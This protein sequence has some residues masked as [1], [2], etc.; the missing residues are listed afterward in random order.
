MLYVAMCTTTAQHFLTVELN[1]Q[2]NASSC[3]AKLHDFH[4]LKNA[5]VLTSILSDGY[6]NVTAWFTK[7]ISFQQK[8]IK[9]LNK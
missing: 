4:T 9:L 5:D 2:L 6:L 1:S 7:N 8:R 3:R